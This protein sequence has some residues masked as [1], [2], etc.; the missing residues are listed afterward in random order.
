MILGVGDQ[1]G[2]TEDDVAAF[3]VENS[4]EAVEER[5]AGNDVLLDDVKVDE[6]RLGRGGGDCGG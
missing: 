1:D 6:G 5:L 2:E 3:R 4:G